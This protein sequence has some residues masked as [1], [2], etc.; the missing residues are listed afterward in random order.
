M[1][2]KGRARAT[3]PTWTFTMILLWTAIAL[4]LGAAAGGLARPDQAPRLARLLLLAAAG[5]VGLLVLAVLVRPMDRSIARLAD[6]IAQALTLVWAGLAAAILV[7][8][9][10]R[11]GPGPPTPPLAIAAIV[12]LVAGKFVV[13]EIGK[14]MHF[15]E[16]VRFFEA[17]GYPAWMNGVVMA[18]ELAGSAGL[19]LYARLNTGVAATAGL[20]VVMVGAVA[21]HLRNGDPFSDSHDAV[22]QLVYLALLAA[23]LTLNRRR[24]AR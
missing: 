4:V 10:R 2:I 19:V 21:T 12:L 18:L 5:V 13:F 23:A 11:D 1:G 9:R 17:S 20:A 16:M 22:L 24:H 14:T 8:A 6:R 7:S 15:Q 3:D